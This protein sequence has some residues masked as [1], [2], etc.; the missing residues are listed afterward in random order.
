MK[1]FNRVLSVLVIVLVVAQFACMLMPYWNLTPIA[2]RLLNPNPQ[3][4]DYSI[5]Q[6]CWTDCREMNDIFE[7]TFK[8]DYKGTP[9]ADYDGNEYAIGLVL[10]CVFGFLAVLFS[11]MKIVK[12]F[13]KLSSATTTFFCSVFSLAW[14]GFG[15]FNVFTNFILTLATYPL[16]YTLLMITT[17]IGAALVL[18]R[19]VV[20]IVVGVKEYRA[21]YCV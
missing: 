13:S 4:T 10:T 21:E 14:I 16:P 9:R 7:N 11:I 6:Y 20:D 15:V 12:S 17:L 19:L 3:P 5:V 1:N 18:V 2:N 8:K